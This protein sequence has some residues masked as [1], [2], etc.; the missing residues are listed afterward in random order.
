MNNLK[1]KDVLPIL[2]VAE[3]LFYSGKTKD[4]AIYTFLKKYKLSLK[5]IESMNV[6]DFIS[7]LD[8]LNIEKQKNSNSDARFEIS[9]LSI[10]EIEKLIEIENLTKKELL[11]IG[12]IKFNIPPGSHMR[13]K[14]EDLIKII[15]S[16]IENKKTLSRISSE[17]SK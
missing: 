15:K 13:T 8:S 17:A 6:G 9:S 2:T 7:Y 14:K 10:E 3:S 16:S 12:K 5:K 1:I 4:E 11:E